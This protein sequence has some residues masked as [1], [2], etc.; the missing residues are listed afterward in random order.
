VQK[1]LGLH[2]EPGHIT[3]F[4]MSPLNTRLLLACC[5][6]A[7]VFSTSCR[8]GDA[9]PPGYS[10]I[11]L[12]LIDSIDDFHL[13]EL[14]LEGDSNEIGCMITSDSVTDMLYYVF[15][16]V[17]NG[18][19][20]LV[21]YSVMPR[22]VVV[23][24][25][26]KGDMTLDISKELFPRFEKFA[27]IHDAFTALQP[28][29]TLCIGF[30]SQ[31]CFGGGSART[32]IQNKNGKYLVEHFCDTGW[33]SGKR[34]PAVFR[35]EHGPEFIDSLKKLEQDCTAKFTEQEKYRVE[36]FEPELKK[37]KD[38]NDSSR[39]YMWYHSSTLSTVMYFNRGNRVFELTN[40][41]V[42]DLPYNEFVQSALKM[43]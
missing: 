23:P 15:D 34:I 41:V 25:T 36:V 37:A 16:S 19:Y 13:A 17:P 29:D 1:I 31:G 7:C 22:K 18:K 14:K 11:R 38:A 30:E 42:V 5:L 28:N 43:K 24:V 39:A 40:A 35:Y 6:L 32:L 26:V 2:P 12:P 3:R 21:F 20:N 10:T 8:N 33:L 9:I 4:A 27:S